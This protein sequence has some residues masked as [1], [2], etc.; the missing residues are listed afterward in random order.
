LRYHGVSGIHHRVKVPARR[1]VF[2]PRALPST[3]RP[4][5]SN[6]PSPKALDSLLNPAPWHWAAFSLFV[7]V[8][9]VLDLCVFHRHSRESTLRE[10]AG[11]TVFWC[12]LAVAFMGLIYFWARQNDPAKAHIPAMEF[13]LGY[14]VEWALSM[15][16][17]FVFAVVFSFFRV[18][19]KYQHRVLFWG[20]LGAIVM[21]LTFILLGAA[22]LERFNWVMVIFGLLLLYTAFKLLVS[23]GADVDPDKNFLLR[24]ARYL[25]PVARGLH[26]E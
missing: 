14:I 4:L 9:L 26:G 19:L 15:D 17:V 25:L 21:R 16:N 10:A 8:M 20:I 7:V 11:W 24:I 3:N 5:T 22:I 1:R 13:M 12:M 2:R 18:P 6:E 23:H